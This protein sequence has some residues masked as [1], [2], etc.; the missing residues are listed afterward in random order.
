MVSIKKLS[1]GI[2]L[3]VSA[4]TRRMQ[5]R[6]EELSVKEVRTLINNKLIPTEKNKHKKT[7]ILFINET[8]AIK[9]L[10][11][12]RR[13]LKTTISQ[14]TTEKAKK[15]ST[16]SPLPANI[17]V[18]G[19]MVWVGKSFCPAVNIGFATFNAFIKEGGF[20]KANIRIDKVGHGIKRSKYK[21]EWPGMEK[22]L[23]I[24]K[25]CYS[26][27]SLEDK[28]DLLRDLLEPDVDG[29][30]DEPELPE[31]I[32][33]IEEIEELKEGAKEVFSDESFSSITS[34]ILS[35]PVPSSKE[36]IKEAF[37]E[38]VIALVEP[39]AMRLKKKG[40]LR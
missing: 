4:W 12:A 15:I 5:K 20:K 21:I 7:C 40:I 9:Q 32:E 30:E 22:A 25:I 39:I 2:L 14:P 18:I 13:K 6:I 19:Q 10:N 38:F 28:Q 31:E 11:V 23:K 8:E 36:K 33:E 24:K 16:N 35:A 17:L 1:S 37:F 27:K 3:T 34:E 29:L 26:H